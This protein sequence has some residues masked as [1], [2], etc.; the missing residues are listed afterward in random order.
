MLRR[1][2]LQGCLSLAP[3]APIVVG[4]DNE[5]KTSREGLVA[6]PS[7][8]VAL[9]PS[10]RA[11][12]L[13]RAGETMSDGLLVGGRPDGMACFPSRDGG[14]VVM[15]N[16]ELEHGKC[17]LKTRAFDPNMAGGVTRLV[18]D[19]KS[20]QV[21]S[22]NW[23]LLGTQ[24]NCAG[25]PSPWGFL[26]CEETTNDGHGYVFLCDPTASETRAPKPLP[27]LGRFRHEAAAVDPHSRIIYLTEDETE[28]A[29]YRHLPG[30][31]PL[32][33]KLQALKVVHAHRRRLSQ[34]LE[35]GQSLRVQW[36]DIDDPSGKSAPTREQAFSRGAAM[37]S[38]GEGTWYHDGSVFVVSTN[39]GPARLGQV[40]RLDV[41]KKPERL[42]LVAQGEDDG[43]LFGPDNIT[44]SPRGEVFVVEDNSGPNHIHR[45][46]EN[47]HVETFAENLI[48]GGKSELCGICFSPDGRIMFVNIQAEG[49]TLAITGPFRS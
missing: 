30:K 17:P 23:V 19:P 5:H 47:G 48:R 10:Y 43:N 38:R 11:T 9:P 37:I 13:Q 7:G 8:I 36:V 12:V 3:G 33:G 41:A 32:S 39:G 21:R 24:R 15:R 44:V 49:L 34:D 20:L 40:F 14:L 4:C 29:L 26:S 31:T 18:V 25:G 42:T 16:H 46:G 27:S 28:S 2:F 6:D 22:S 35:V 1:G 45:I